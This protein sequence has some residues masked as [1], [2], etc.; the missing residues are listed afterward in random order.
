MKVNILKIDNNTN[1]LGDK[2]SPN[3]NKKNI[4]I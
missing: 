4:N 1:C 2:I 3:E